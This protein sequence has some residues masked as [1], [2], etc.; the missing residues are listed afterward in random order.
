MNSKKIIVISS[1][2]LVLSL[3]IL[4]FFHADTKSSPWKKWHVIAVEKTISENEVL[5]YLSKIK[6]EKIV[7][8]S[9]PRSNFAPEMTPVLPSSLFGTY[10][11]NQDKYFYD[12]SGNYRLYYIPKR[13]PSSKLKD[14]PFKIIQDLNATNYI[15][16]FSFILF[17]YIFCAFFYKNSRLKFCLSSFPFLIY[18]FFNSSLQSLFASVFFLTAFLLWNKT[19]N[20]RYR[21]E[22][23]IKNPY[24][25]TMISSSL[26]CAALGLWK[27]FVLYLDTL[28]LCASIYVLFEQLQSVFSK[29]SEHFNYGRIV[30]SYWI[31]KV[32]SKTIYVFYTLC[33]LIIVS[34]ILTFT[35]PLAKNKKSFSYEIPCPSR[36][37]KK[38]FSY[39]AY[40]KA[41]KNGTYENQLPNLSNYVDQVW[42]GLSISYGSLNK[43]TYISPVKKKATIYNLE[44]YEADGKIESQIVPI[45]KFSSS[46]IKKTISNIKKQDYATLETILVNQGGIYKVHYSGVKN[47]FLIKLIV[48]L[49]GLFFS[50]SDILLFFVKKKKNRN[51]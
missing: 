33:A 17:F 7:S 10:V 43:K 26:I 3:F 13:I 16:L 31:P 24:I 22:V 4:L 32:N 11:K 50:C 51:N 36:T 47:D 12:K 8:I 21:F 20:R 42:N 23:T 18:F 44:Y 19:E 46:F 40:R 35:I 30:G 48:M 9:S 5:N 39:A 2:F 38:G 41:E 29:K 28:V 14:A 6:I 1:V 49:M 34:G 25:L 45:E 27:S 37:A 15:F